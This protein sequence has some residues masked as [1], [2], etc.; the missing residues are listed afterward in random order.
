[1]SG[2]SR[3]WVVCLFVLLTKDL[4]SD[5]AFTS[6]SHLTQSRV[7]SVAQ[8]QSQDYIGTYI[9]RNLFVPISSIAYLA[10]S[11]RFS[12]SQLKAKVSHTLQQY[13]VG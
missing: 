8:S 3:I 13:Q 1:M 10:H 5:G 6:S 7:Q 11:R 4:G 2:G 12:H 9:S